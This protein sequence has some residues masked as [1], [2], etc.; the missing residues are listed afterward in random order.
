MF[1][2]ISL[3]IFSCVLLAALSIYLTATRTQNVVT[4]RLEMIDPSLAVMENNPMTVMAERV[5]EPLNRIVP[6]SAVEAEKLQRQLLLAGYPSP[7]A[8][9]TY[10]A[11]PLRW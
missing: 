4:A 6:I 8:A 9:M 2:L 5:A 10:R 11:I 3:L 1:L 7:D